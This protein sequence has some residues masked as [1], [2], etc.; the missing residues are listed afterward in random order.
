MFWPSFHTEM[1]F[2]VL[3]K[4]VSEEILKKNR[5]FFHIVVWIVKTKVFL[6]DGILY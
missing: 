3:Q 4:Q 6:N 2:F 1:P 5:V